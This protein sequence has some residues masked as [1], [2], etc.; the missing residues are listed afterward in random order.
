MNTEHDLLKLVFKKKDYKQ[1]NNINIFFTGGTGF[2]GKWML[3]ALNYIVSKLYGG[4]YLGLNIGPSEP[5]NT[6]NCSSL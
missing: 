5:A 6:T 3:M 2:L 1:L 4:I